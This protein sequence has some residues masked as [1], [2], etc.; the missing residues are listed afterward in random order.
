MAGTMKVK[1]RE[2][3]FSSV[4]TIHKRAN[5]EISREKIK[6]K[7]IRHTPTNSSFFIQILVKFS[8]ALYVQNTNYFAMNILFLYYP[9]TVQFTYLDME[10]HP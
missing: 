7:K 6:K 10:S 8:S 4:H 9:V 2:A 1:S 3:P 5:S